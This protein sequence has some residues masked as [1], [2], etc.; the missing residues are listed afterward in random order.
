MIKTYEPNKAILT[1][2]EVK[3]A[4]SLDYDYTSDRLENLSLEASQFLYQKTNHDW[5]A[6]EKINATA[7]GAARDY[8]YQI[9]F[10]SDDHV[11]TRLDDAII[12]LQSMVDENGDL[13]NDDNA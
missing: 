10:G 5:S 8:I 12:I 2:K 4:L 11:Q 6:D 9:W 3:E 1:D 7:K 13:Y